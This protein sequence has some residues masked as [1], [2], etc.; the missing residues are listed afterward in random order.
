MASAAGT[1]SGKTAAERTRQVKE[2]VLLIPVGSVVEVETTGKVKYR[3]RLM[4]SSDEQFVI[5]TVNAD[6]VIEKDF[7][8]TETKSVKAL[9]VNGAEQFGGKTSTA[10]WV[11][12]GGLAALGVL[13]VVGIAAAVAGGY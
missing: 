8:F 5:Q 11:L 2:K 10:G 12:I 13:A 9:K 6:R 3:G 7:G 4:S 1:A